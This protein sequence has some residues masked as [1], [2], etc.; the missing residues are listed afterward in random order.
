MSTVAWI[1]TGIVVFDLLIAFVIVRSLVKGQ[2]GPLAARF[3]PV[4]HGLNPERRSYQSF[5][6]GLLNLGWSI[7]V[8]LD[9]THLHLEPERWVAWMGL[10][11]MSLPRE[12]L[13]PQ[14]KPRGRLW[15]HPIRVET[16]S[17]VPQTLRGPMWL[18][19]VLK[20]SES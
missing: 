17:R 16:G 14:G 5:S 3:P 6:F 19:E 11:A 18:W 7:R 10:P 20:E 13:Q 1:I 9:Q 12:S 8:T 4:A 2:L 15:A